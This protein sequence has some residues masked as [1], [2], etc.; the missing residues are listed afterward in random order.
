MTSRTLHTAEIADRILS[1]LRAGRS[2]HD[3]CRDNGM[4]CRDTVLEWVRQDRDGFAARYRQA[5]ETGHGS[6][7]PV[8]YTPQLA[9]RF[10]EELMA[11]R[12]LVEVCCDP[13]MPCTTTINKWVA[14][15]RE[16]FAARYRAARQVGQLSQAEVP[17]TADVADR[18]LDALMSG[19]P[20]HDICAEPD[21]PS[22]VSV[23]HWLKDNREGFTARY[24]EAREIGYH[25]IADQM[26]RIVD[27]RR[28]DWIV[29]RQED[30]SFETML[31]PARVNRAELRVKTRRWL[32]SKM[33]PKQFGDRLDITARRDGS[34]TKGG[35]ESDLAELMKLINGR[36]RGLPSEDEPFD[37]A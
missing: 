37:E 11:G 24:W 21:M 27:D 8:G 31:D 25:A 33:L 34:D 28:N 18:I 32:L 15:D 19:Q 36:S 16:G 17:Y 2:V 23:R 7:G 6:P 35:D 1:E 4:P 12:T 3:I 10:L 22:A 14:T 20:L 29:R 9:D 5:R 26:L 30:G 13:G